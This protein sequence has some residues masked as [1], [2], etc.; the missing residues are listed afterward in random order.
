[1]DCVHE[2]VTRRPLTGTRSR[3]ARRC[4]IFSILTEFSKSVAKRTLSGLEHWN[5]KV[6]VHEN[7]RPFLRICFTPFVCACAT[8]HATKMTSTNPFAAVATILE[9]PLDDPV[10]SHLLLKLKR[11]P[12]RKRKV[13]FTDDT[14][15]NEDLCRKKSKNCC[16]FHR[17]QAPPDDDDDGGDDDTPGDAHPEGSGASPAADS[18]SS[19]SSSSEADSAT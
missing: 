9:V 8:Q 6:S 11:K 18:G 10:P 1:M 2:A 7:G 17:S 14:I 15:D 19:S 13:R 16:V 3:L 5:P 12:E 4:S